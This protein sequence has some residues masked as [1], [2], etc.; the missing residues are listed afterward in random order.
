M[1]NRPQRFVSQSPHGTLCAPPVDVTSDSLLLA[2]FVGARDETA[3]ATLV[4]RHG[5]MV[6]GV[7]RRLLRDTHDAEDAF[8]ATF[9]VLARKAATLRQPELLASWLYGVAYRVASKARARAARRLAHERQVAVMPRFEPPADAAQWEVRALLDEELRRLPDKYRAPLVLCYLEGMTNEQA[10]RKLGWPIGS[11]SARLARG[12]ELLRRRL[13]RRG[14]LL[15][16]APFAF[17]LSECTA[18]A[19]VPP[20]LA[21][22]AVNSALLYTAAETVVPAS[23]ALAET[24][25]AIGLTDVA[26]L[27][28]RADLTDATAEVSASVRSLAEDTLLAM[29]IVGRPVLAAWLVVLAVFL[30]GASVTTYAAWTTNGFTAWTCR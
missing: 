17:L 11:M 23:A 15:A 26:E 30:G 21:T 1:V 13:S 19:A 27:S 12:R 18:V 6:L 10:A 3:F 24:T 8:Q 22:A 5:P 7:C 29:A 25:E 20:A 9:L 4:A 14:M 16:A 2:R 28:E